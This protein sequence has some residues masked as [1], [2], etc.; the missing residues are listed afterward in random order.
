MKK[1]T[2][3]LIVALIFCAQFANA[4]VNTDAAKSAATATSSSFDAVANASSTKVDSR[5]ARHYT[6]R[7][8]VKQSYESI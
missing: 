3:T 1:L 8:K 6:E 7:T 5:R 2:I 4:Q